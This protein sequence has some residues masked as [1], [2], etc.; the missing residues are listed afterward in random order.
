MGAR[1][2]ALQALMACRQEG[3]WSNAV[4]K[5]L[6]RR[7]RLDPRD[8]GLATRLCYG[9]LQNRMKLDFFLQQ[10]LTMKLRD[11]HPVARDILHMGLYQ[12][13]EMDKIPDSAAVNE[14]VAL[15]RNM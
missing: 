12:L 5:D 1:E 6:I 4:L 11:L 2:P 14:S 15:T 7:D 10:L 8:A 13:Y 3:A 9:V